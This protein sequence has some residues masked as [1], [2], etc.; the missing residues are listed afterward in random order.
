MN[1]DISRTA[2]PALAVLPAPSL[3]TESILALFR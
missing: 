1:Q 2:R 3:R